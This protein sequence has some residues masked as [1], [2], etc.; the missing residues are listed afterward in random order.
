MP[1]QQAV[2]NAQSPG[3]VY[4]S[5]NGPPAAFRE[6]LGTGSLPGSGEIS[7]SDRESWHTDLGSGNYGENGPPAGV[8]DVFTN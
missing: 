4:D 8:G 6:A 2:A 1:T 7:P 5:E 3:M